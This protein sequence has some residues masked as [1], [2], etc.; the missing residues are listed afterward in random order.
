[1]TE[2]SDTSSSAGSPVARKE[3]LAPRG[4]TAV[5]LGAG[6]SRDAGLPLT[7]ELA[8]R[9]VRDFDDGLVLTQPS[10]GLRPEQLLRA[11]HMVYGAMVARATERGDSPLAAVNVEHLV[12]AVRL[13]RDRASH[14]AAAF[15]TWRPSV[16]EVDSH[17]LTVRDDDLSKHISFDLNRGFDVRGLSERVTQ[18]VRDTVAP[19]NGNTFRE[20][21][22]HLVR[23]IARVLAEPKDVSYLRPL[24]E[25]ARSQE[26]G[27]DVAT[28]NYDTTVELAARSFD[29][30][31]DTGVERWRPGRALIFG[32]RERSIN[33]MKLHG[34]VD[35]SRSR[36]SSST[37]GY[38]F[39]RYLWEW[40]VDPRSNQSPAII[41]GDREKLTAEGPT[42]AL[43]RSFEDSLRR[44]NRLVVVGYSFGDDHINTVIGNWL[45]G[46]RARSIVILDPG[47]PAA[48]QMVL[49]H[50]APLSMR[51]ALQFVAGYSLAVEP[52]RIVVIK[53]PAASGLEGALKAEPL[54]RLA[55]ELSVVACL[56]E[57]PFLRLTNHGYD[58]E[59]VV[60]EVMQ[61]IGG[62][63]A[64][65]N[66]RLNASEDG[67]S[68]LRIPSLRHG[69]S[70]TVFFD[71]KA[72]TE[73]SAALWIAGKTW[74]SSVS[75]HPTLILQDG[76]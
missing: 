55:T 12:S 56:G 8:Q 63:R 41:V 14:E 70:A 60:V 66:L 53:R 58:I 21:E 49:P 59:N 75:L 26:G 15:V 5:L 4:R 37:P 73:N 65:D 27:L 30:Q 72:L 48:Q 33:L 61:G 16:E 29:V 22:T 44:A 71:R 36:S 9:L 6:A 74:R 2:A 52:G 50:D 76:A 32:R 45:G 43:M 34:S 20:L 68:S 38:P 57:Q 23:R 13:L 51:E 10:G 28:L 31:I 69:E 24:I 40:G 17:T 3:T 54:P 7:E 1:M 47:W 42:L 64:V 39:Q 62:V 19:G 67:S 18:I 46:D 35:W 11:L 25:L